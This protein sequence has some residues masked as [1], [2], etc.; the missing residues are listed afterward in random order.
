MMAACKVHVFLAIWVCGPPGNLAE[1]VDLPQALTCP[2]D[3]LAG[4]IEGVQKACCVPG[5]AG[6]GAPADVCA[7]GEPPLECDIDCAATFVPFYADCSELLAANFDSI[8]EIEDHAAKAIDGMNERCLTL[9]QDGIITTIVQLQDA[10]CTVETSGIVADKDGKMGRRALQ[11]IGYAGA[12]SCSL[13]SFDNRLAEVN[14]NC[15]NDSDEDD[16]CHADIPSSCDFEC[17]AVWGRF[18]T[19][20][21]MIITMM[22]PGALEDFAKVTATCNALPQ[23][24]LIAAIRN[25]IAA[26]D[27]P[28]SSA[29]A[30]TG[31]LMY[32][33]PAGGGGGL[34]N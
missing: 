5:D 28:V 23:P 7:N 27:C 17:A 12:D 15:C 26:C 9:E 21:N 4:R 24:L 10:G 20:C 1:W 13:G 3:H 19:D 32:N 6:V 11:Q 2:L 22:M 14:T 25:S 34:Y 16:N 8:D 31:G 30:V 18:V 33:E 29:L